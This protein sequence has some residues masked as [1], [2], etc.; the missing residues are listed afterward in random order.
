MEKRK[1]TFRGGHND[2]GCCESALEAVRKFLDEKFTC[3]GSE[4]LLENVTTQIRS[5]K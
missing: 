5:W 2:S 4:H 3:F 1:G